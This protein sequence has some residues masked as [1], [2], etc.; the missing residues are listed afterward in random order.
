[1]TQ[2][3]HNEDSRVKLPALLHFKRLGYEYQSKKNTAIDIRNNI[4]VDVFSDSIKRI[5]NKDYDEKFINN[6]I[7]E[8]ATLTDNDKDKGKSFHERLTGFNTVKLIDLR[9][10]LNN[11]FRVVTELTFAGER[12]E[13][14]P[15]ITILINGIP[16]AFIE[17]K[18]PNNDKGI[19]AEF[20]RMDYRL[21]VDEFNHFF[22]Q[23]Q[24]LAFTNNQPYDDESRVKLQGSFYTAPNG[25]DTTFNHFR[26]EKELSIN[27]FIDEEFIKSVLIDNSLLSIKDSSEFQT[28]MNSETYANKFITSLFSKERLMY[29]IRYG[30]AYVD[31]PRDGLQKHI[32]RYPQYFAATGLVE[33]L[34]HGM[35]RGVIWHTQGSGKTALAYYAANVLRDYFQAKNIITKFYFVVDR[36]DLLHQASS[37]FSS[38]GMTIASINSKED[39]AENIK[40]TVIVPPTSQ[41]GRYLETMNVVNIHKFSED[42]T[43]K[44]NVNVSIQRIYF[45]DEVHRGYKPRGTF[46]ANLLGADENGIFIGL[47]GTPILK[48]EFRTT[49]LFHD[50][51]HKYYYNK[52]IA[53]GYTLKIKKENIATEFRNDVRN[54]LDVKQGHRIP[55]AKWEEI[56]K[57]PEFVEKLCFYIKDDFDKFR[58]EVFNDKSLGSMIVT[59]SSEQARAIQEWFKNN[60]EFKTALVLYDEENNKEKQEEFRGKRNK[61]NNNQIES[62]YDG[63]VVY[64]MLLTGFDA[65]RLKRLYLLREIREHSLLQT[66]ARV[67]RPYKKMKYGYIVDFVDITEEYEATNQ[68][69]LDELKKDILDEE[70][71]QDTVEMFIDVAKVKTQIQ[72]IENTLFIYMANIEGNLE[73]FSN[74]LM[75]LDEAKLREIKV[76]LSD[77][78]DCYN[79]LRMSHED[80]SNIPIDRI[81]K[82][83]Y[84]VSNRINL[85]VAERL[86]DDPNVDVS[87]IDFTQLVFEFL[88]VGEMDLNFDTENDILDIVNK[89]RNAFSANIDRVDERFVELQ[90]Q[91]REIV[92]RF[93][94]G[95]SSTQ[96]VEDVIKALNQL[97]NQILVLNSNNNGLTARYHGDDS[98]MRIHKRILSQYS[99]HLNDAMIYSIMTTIIKEIDESLGNMPNP[100]QPVIMRSMKRPVAEAFRANG[101][102]ISP[103][104]VES[105]V[106]IFIDDKFR[107]N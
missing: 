37:E 83:F 79:E 24:V 54:I 77:Y 6:L 107:S 26:E 46:L 8:I 90:L 14:R 105:I 89:I 73:D 67:N 1:M 85:K 3:V 61:D 58:N 40:S 27:S 43:V 98:C 49:D 16:L 41:E 69:Y 5:N 23:F 30:I 82:A 25:K 47:T 32:I 75:P 11:D 71:G 94:T 76:A 95:Y 21:K 55:S 31:S 38:R 62:K 18:K 9:N 48:N 7:K 96:Q 68:R 80:V 33:K 60:T 87:E 20:Q 2:T 91:F 72:E 66:L 103:R 78:R 57:Q 4:F 64:N 12:E 70:A 59:S 15:D 86:L 101:I 17:V 97:L 63:V 93:K 45:L 53:D 81:N 52:S 29:F 74:Q 13:F 100:T 10:P 104:Q 34:N 88:K 84:E 28:N 19:Q 22:N 36:L 106:T 65:P 92:R 50:Y 42:S 102:T 35:K 44:L 51:I 56:T 39:F 99:Q